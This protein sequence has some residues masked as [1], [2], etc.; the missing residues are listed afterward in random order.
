M[1]QNADFGAFFDTQP[2]YSDYPWLGSNKLATLLRLRFPCLD[3]LD[4]D[5]MAKVKDDHRDEFEAFSRTILNAVEASKACI[6]TSD[7]IFETQK[8]QRD[9]IDAGLADVQ[10]S[11]NKIKRSPALQR[12]GCVRKQLK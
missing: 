8:I 6:G 2:L 11:V 10:R 4:L 9:I 5:T 1:R 3:G 12:E 7:F